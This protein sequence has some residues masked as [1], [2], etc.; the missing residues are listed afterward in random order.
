MKSRATSNKILKMVDNATKCKFGKHRLGMRGLMLATLLILTGTGVA[1]TPGD[2]GDGEP[3]DLGAIWFVGDSITQS[4]ADEDPN[5]SPRKALYDLLIAQ[6]YSFSY[7]G[8]WKGSV[9]GLPTTGNTLAENLYHYHSGCSGAVI[10]EPLDNRV[11]IAQ[12]LPEFWKTGRLAE[13]KPDVILIMLGSNDIHRDLN[14]EAAPTRM[15]NLLDAIYTLPDLGNP[16]VLLGSIPPTT[17]ARA[18]K[19][20]V[21][22][23]ATLPGI[24]AEYRAQGRDIRFVDHFTAL[25]NNYTSNMRTDNLHPNAAG[26]QAIAREW[27]AVLTA[28]GR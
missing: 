16:T 19:D 14:C 4:N 2:F 6:D 1:K 13:V 28:P 8:H 25:N 23:N 21:S 22:F 26:N 3:K 20:V 12:S 18:G 5:G 17:K 24:V 7:T 9:D 11:G 10:Q 27:F 15:R